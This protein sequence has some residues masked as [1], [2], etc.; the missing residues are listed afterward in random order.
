MRKEYVALCDGNIL[1]IENRNANVFS[2]FRTTTDEK[3]LVNINLSSQKQQLEYEFLKSGISAK[4]L[5]DQ[6]G[7]TANFDDSSINL[8][9]YGIQIIKF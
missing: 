8:V 5:L 3:I 7:L 1:F 9:P 4:L 2:F 6:N